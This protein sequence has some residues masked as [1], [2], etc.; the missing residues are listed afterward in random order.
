MKATIT[1]PEFFEGISFSII[2]LYIYTKNIFGEN[3]LKFSLKCT[4]L[5]ITV[6]HDRLK[7]GPLVTC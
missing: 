7:P 1:S 4:A 6:V 3:C 5:I 2:Y